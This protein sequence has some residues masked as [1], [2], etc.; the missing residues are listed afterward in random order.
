MANPKLA[1]LAQMT[2]TTVGTG[3]VALSSA[4]RGYN[5][6]SSAGILNGD[7]VSYSIFDLNNHEFGTGVVSI[8]GSTTS[9]TRVFG[10]STTGS[11]LSLS[12]S[13]VVT[14]TPRAED[15]YLY[16]PSIPGGV[17]RNIGTKLED[18]PSIEDFGSVT[19]DA[20]STVQ[21]ALNYGGRILCR[22]K[23]YTIGG[24]LSTTVPFWLSGQL[25]GLGSTRTLFNFTAAD[26][27]DRL[28]IGDGISSFSGA[29]IEGITFATPNATGGSVIFLNYGNKFSLDYNDFIT[30][31]N[32]Q[33]AIKIWKCNTTRIRGSA[34][35]QPTRS[36]IYAYS[37]AIST[38]DRSDVIEL[39]DINVSGDAGGAGTHIPDAFLMD[40][41]VDTVTMHSVRAV[42]VGRGIHIRNTLGA[43]DGPAFIIAHD[44]E[45][46]YPQYECILVDAG[47]GMWIHNLY[48]H[49]SRT[50][51]NI[52]VNSGTPTI[53]N[54]Q[55]VG[56]QC[57]GANQN[58]MYL[59]GRYTTVTAM[60]ISG[61]SQAG[62]G[63]YPGIEIGPN[64]Q[65]IRIVGNHIGSRSGRSAASHSYGVLV[66]SGATYY[67]IVNN[68]LVGN[69]TGTINDL[70]L[71]TVGGN[72]IISNNVGDGRS[73]G[74][75]SQWINVASSA[76]VIP[77]TGDAVE[78]TI[79]TVSIP[80]NSM[81]PN[82]AVRITWMGS[83]TSSV[84]NKI[85]RVKWAGVTTQSITQTTNSTSMNVLEITNRNLTNSQVASSVN[86][87]GYGTAST[88]P[89]TS[90]V[91]TTAAVSLT[92]TVQLSTITETINLER[93]C[94]EVI[95]RP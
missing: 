79:L 36:A 61:N 88:S 1:N 11:L 29:H 47:I 41:I 16:T 31:G 64:S 38:S 70:S 69:I 10:G 15:I 26:A 42:N 93:Y 82:G 62:V 17:A 51:R 71:K 89:I 27:S 40:G 92:F 37:S 85:W 18:I 81:G 7:T 6:F 8:A 48:A 4:T 68:D 58:G 60:E 3:T 49:G 14:I 30:L 20:T 21:L 86:N 65:N 28:T 32:T 33:D 45:C 94:V 59:N 75:T 87:S 35:V 50:A 77:H 46:D 90:S 13:A 43:P 78:T 74:V 67:E 19:G 22:S 2:T 56:G 63:T 23:S 34:I 24:T 91:D 53:D 73:L 66:D 83:G 76:I 9:M 12:G 44:F 52:V 57:T 55:F 54:I 5:S 72:A 25:S 84:N 80:A 95:Y 39:M